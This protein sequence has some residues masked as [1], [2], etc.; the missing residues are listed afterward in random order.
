[1]KKVTLEIL[2]FVVPLIVSLIAL[3]VSFLTLK[4]TYLIPADITGHISSGIVFSAAE[5]TEDETHT[6]VPDITIPITF[7]NNGAQTEYVRQLALVLG[8]EDGTRE[9]FKSKSEH[10]SLR[11]LVSN[12][13]QKILESIGDP[14]PEI[15]MFGKS[16]SVHKVSF[17]PPVLSHF[18]FPEK[19]HKI[20][21]SLF[22]IVGDSLKWKQLDTQNVEFIEGEGFQYKLL[23]SSLKDTWCSEELIRELNGSSS[24][25]LNTLCNRK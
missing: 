4:L 9:V 16:Q 19:L 12:D 5:Q 3:G 14:F 13:S 24:N 23:D 17:I 22:A 8:F 15:I 21:L 6:I 11:S 2:K 20:E 18:T 25:Q 1:M 10:S 7:T